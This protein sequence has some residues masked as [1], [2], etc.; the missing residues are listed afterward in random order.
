[1]S[2]RPTGSG[3]ERDAVGD[4]AETQGG[5]GPGTGGG[6]TGRDKRREGQSEGRGSVGRVGTTGR[7]EGKPKPSY[8]EADRTKAAGGGDGK[9]KI[10]RLLW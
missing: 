8:G 2:G 10:N 1:M 7:T 6:A 4:R 9:Q 3:G 5:A